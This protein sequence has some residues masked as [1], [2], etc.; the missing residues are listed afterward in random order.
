MNDTN[1]IPAGA[2]HIIAHAKHADDPEL[3]EGAA[4][5]A[6]QYG[7]DLVFR[8]T[9]GPGH[10]SELAQKAAAAGVGRVIAVG[11]DGTINEIVSGLMSVAADH[12][13]AL[14][15]VPRG[16]ANDFASSAGLALELGPALVQAF[17]L[18]V[19][20]IDIG[21]FC[22][23]W[24]VNVV[25]GGVFS[26]ATAAVSD[27]L[28]QLMGGLAYA[29]AGI[30]GL[31]AMRPIELQIRG[32]TFEWAGPCYALGVGNARTAGGGFALCPGASINDG[33]LNLT[34]IP[35]GLGVADVAQL[36][37]ERGVAAIAAIPQFCSPWIEF[38]TDAP[39]HVNLDGEPR[40]FSGGRVDLVARALQIVL[41]SNSPLLG[42][43]SINHTIGGS[44]CRAPR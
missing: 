12:R 27:G 16:T 18:P 38:A 22:G 23:E 42:C 37:D 9:T 44:G 2:I 19:H 3:R 17:T 34:V 13:P 14:G 8:P 35:V 28:K 15:V 1:D 25:S 21:R 43:G 4:A 31:P 40:C 10:A 11:G 39:L 7:W 26:E 20:A 32:E 5:L 41:P 30:L 29:V 24:F 6:A 33:L 36:I